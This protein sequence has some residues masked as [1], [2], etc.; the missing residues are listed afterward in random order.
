MESNN[1][2]KYML[3]ILSLFLLSSFAYANELK[4]FKATDSFTGGGLDKEYIFFYPNNEDSNIDNI[5]AD[6]MAAKVKM[7]DSAC[8]QELLRTNIKKGLTIY[9]MYQN[10]SRDKL[11]ILKI[12]S[13]PKK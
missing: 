8:K 6:T 13:C 4:V 5:E 7:I 9:Y 2:K 1:M 3:S 10:K 12:D 11:A